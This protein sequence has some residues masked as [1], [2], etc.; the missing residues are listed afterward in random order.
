MEFKGTG[1]YYF[2]IIPSVGDAVR[3]TINFADPQVCEV[4]GNTVGGRIVSPGAFKTKRQEFKR[5]K[6]ARPQSVEVA[7]IDRD[8]ATAVAMAQFTRG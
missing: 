8:T 5:M 7:V 4:I 1:R 3:S 2:L 6:R